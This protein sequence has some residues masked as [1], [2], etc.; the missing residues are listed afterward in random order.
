MKKQKDIEKHTEELIEPILERLG[1][2]LYDI[3]YVKEG[4]D[5]YLR[6][7]IEKEGGITID[8]C[9]TVSREMNELLDR[10]DYVEGSYIF[11]V[12]SPGLTRKLTKDRHFEKSLEKKVEL[13]AFRPVKG[14][15]DWKGVLAGFDA[16]TLTI[17]L[18]DG[19]EESFQRNEIASVRLAFIGNTD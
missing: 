12:S 17:R 10:E 14:E 11:E 8:D 16:N 5:Y 3:E 9:E 19:S 6:A 1:F 2:S 15:K 18:E 7:Y 4:S 13:K